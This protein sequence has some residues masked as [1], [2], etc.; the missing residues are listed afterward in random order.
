MQH[1]GYPLINPLNET[2]PPDFY[3][4][5]TDPFEISLMTDNS[6][7]IFRVPHPR[8]GSWYAMAYIG[9]YI[10]DKITQKV[11]C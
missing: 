4:K 10:N 6:T 11:C 1:G 5:R 7:T 8:P 3:L 9:D 2:F